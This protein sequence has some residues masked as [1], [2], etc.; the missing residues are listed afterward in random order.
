MLCLYIPLVH[1]SHHFRIAFSLPSSF[2]SCLHLWAHTHI[3]LCD[4]RE[5]RRV[6]MCICVMPAIHKTA[7]T[8]KIQPNILHISRSIL[9]HTQFLWE[10][11]KFAF[12]S[13]SQRNIECVLLPQ[14]CRVELKIM[15]STHRAF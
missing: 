4:I 10:N 12:A 6:S 14:L 1:I 3:R 7:S 2:Y 11:K 15:K 8:H 13:P 9:P 5:L